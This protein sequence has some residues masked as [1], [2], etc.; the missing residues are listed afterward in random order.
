M[1]TGW[2]W[3]CLPYEVHHPGG[4]EEQPSLR[5]QNR[6]PK[7]LPGKG[8]AE[9]W[10][11]LHLSLSCRCDGTC[12]V[13]RPCSYK[14][15]PSVPIH[16]WGVCPSPEGQAHKRDSSFL[17]QTEAVRQWYPDHRSDLAADLSDLTTQR[18]YRCCCHGSKVG[19]TWA[20]FA[21]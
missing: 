16:S 2:N 5:H 19:E 7:Q 8:D 18:T 1:R 4:Q 13:K 15:G 3:R 9:C 10:N 12:G 21:K 14:R 17:L 11:G 20:F 6:R